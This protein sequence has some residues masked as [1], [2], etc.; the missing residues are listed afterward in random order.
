VATDHF[1]VPTQSGVAVT[2]GTGRLHDRIPPP[3]ARASHHPRQA[4][5]DRPGFSGQS[6]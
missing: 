5:Q 4:A 6:S 1:S 2:K 3:T